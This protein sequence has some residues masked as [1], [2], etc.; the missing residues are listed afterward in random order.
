MNFLQFCYLDNHSQ[1]LEHN[2]HSPISK[3]SSTIVLYD[4]IAHQV[5]I[6][7]L[8]TTGK[9]LLDINVV[10]VAD[11]RSPPERQVATNHNSVENLCLR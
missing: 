11:A 4:R 5:T 3:F 10:S 7:H 8:L 2:L 9:R 1:T 6:G